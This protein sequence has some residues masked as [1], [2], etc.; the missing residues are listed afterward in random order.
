M[1][2]L[3]KW[4]LLT[5]I[6]AGCQKNEAVSEFTGNQATY[7]LQQ[8][9][10]YSVSGT[11]VFRER[12]DGQVSAIIQLVGTEGDIKH[13]VHLHL[14][15]ISKPDADVALLLNPV[16]GSTG[17]SETVFG[18]LADESPIDYNR[19]TKLQACVKIHL[20]ETGA[21]RDII[22]VGGNIGSSFVDAPSSG[23]L[24]MSVCKSE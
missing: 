4:V 2:R 1:R 8:G 6:A 17:K 23:R 16:V 15:D 14:G 12:K 19:L 3:G 11:V 21:A 13:P 5:M 20:G 18:A 22:L 7:S 24:G 9:S 10:V